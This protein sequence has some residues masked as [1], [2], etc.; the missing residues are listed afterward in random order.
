MRQPLPIKNMTPQSEH[1]LRWQVFSDG[2]TEAS[3]AFAWPSGT[4]R[5]KVRFHATAFLIHHPD[6]GLI[7][8]DT[9]YSK[10]FFRLTA[11]GAGRIHR[12]LTPV[13]LTEPAGI[14]G[15][16]RKHGI[17]ARDIRHLI[18]THFHVDHIG[19]LC[20]FP[21]SRIYCS[22]AAWQGVKGLKGFKALRRGFFPELLPNDIE[23]RL[24]F[25]AEGSNP[26]P[27]GSLRIY[28][29]PGHA[30]GQIGIGFTSSSGENV[31]LAADACWLSDAFRQCRMPHVLTR[32]I[33]DGTA[34]GLT[35]RR[36]YRLHGGHPELRIV[37]SHC[38]ETA[39]LIEP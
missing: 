39:Q 22:A 11:T 13:T 17:E 27:D 1:K 5:K 34:Y 30:I 33:H 19:G 26:F 2:Y 9:G 7:L 10:R 6:Q 15:C 35:L 8:V 29:L 12:W 23:S 38:P 24:T 25:V 20:D 14:A 21:E 28:D 37:P 31:M 32:L 36:L 3:E 4:W 18:L 16:L